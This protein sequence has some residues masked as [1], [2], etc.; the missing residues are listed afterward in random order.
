MEIAMK[1]M[2]TKLLILYKGRPYNKMK[3][4]SVNI[5]DIIK[6]VNE[7]PNATWRDIFQSVPNN[8]RNHRA[9]SIS[10]RQNKGFNLR[11]NRPLI[12]KY[13]DIEWRDVVGYEGI[14]LVNRR[15]L[16]FSNNLKRCM[17][18][19]VGEVNQ[20][21]VYLS[22][23]GMTAGRLV[24]RL[25]AEAFIPNPENKPEI[26]HI[27]ANRRNNHVSNLEWCTGA[28]NVRHAHLHN[29]FPK[30][31]DK[32]ESKLNEFQVRVIRK[33]NDLSNRHLG[34]IFGI[35]HNNIGDIKNG[36]TWRHILPLSL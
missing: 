13:G 31:E 17:G 19:T 30:G 12:S 14:Y 9:M 10:L 4:K 1:N 3:T 25:V 16:V 21:H 2:K 33:C 6:Y 36:V 29:L 20:V 32:P 27:D 11:D 18:Q 5:D 23:N 34:R 7:N 26:N 28:E 15:G 35:S 8:Y 22:K 24:H